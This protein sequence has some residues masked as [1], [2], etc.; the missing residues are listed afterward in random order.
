MA[1]ESPPSYYSIDG[2]A[3]RNRMS[4]IPPRVQ[5]GIDSG[6]FPIQR[7]FE[8]ENPN[9]M[10]VFLEKMPDLPEKLA[11]QYRE[12]DNHHWGLYVLANI[13]EFHC[14]PSE[15]KNAIAG[16]LLSFIQKHTTPVSEEGNR[17]YALPSKDTLRLEVYNQVMQL[18]SM[19]ENHPHTPEE[20]PDKINFWFHQTTLFQYPLYQHLPLETKKDITPQIVAFMRANQ[21]FDDEELELE[22]TRCAL[23]WINQKSMNIHSLDPL[24]IKALQ[25]WRSHLLQSPVSIKIIQDALF[26]KIDTLLR[27]D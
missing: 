25:K 9:H 7:L 20:Y 1:K 19:Y 5:Q 6:T 17:R 4:S 11:I 21:D 16:N 2:S 14:L 3:A 12:T 18:A 23:N 26:Q 8:D 22:I 10:W 27:K 24:P 15:M 13:D